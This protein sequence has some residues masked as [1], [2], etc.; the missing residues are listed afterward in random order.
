VH[1]NRLRVIIGVI[2]VT[3]LVVIH[4]IAFWLYQA[5]Y[6]NPVLAKIPEAV[7][8]WVDLFPYHSTWY[9]RIPLIVYAALAI[10][11][12]ALIMHGYIYGSRIPL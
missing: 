10:L 1:K 9:S 7:R 6:Y 12:I 4:P 5:F 3:I 11:W 2:S 8:P